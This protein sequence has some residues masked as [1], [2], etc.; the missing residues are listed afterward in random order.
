MGNLLVGS[1]GLGLAS[2]ARSC[3]GLRMLAMRY[4][5]SVCRARALFWR[6][7]WGAG[8]RRIRVIVFGSGAARACPP[9]WDR[10]DAERQIGEH[11]ARWSVW[12]RACGV[13][14]AL[15]PLRYEETN[16]LNTVVEGGALVRGIA[17]SGATLLAD[18]YHMARNG[19]PPDSILPWA[20]LLSHTHVAERE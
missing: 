12:A 20:S 1:M 3:A 14:L 15:E 9:D 4:T 18:L 6:A 7:T 5:T 8:R 19:E 10:A 16:T 11:L 13:T 2:C 17:A